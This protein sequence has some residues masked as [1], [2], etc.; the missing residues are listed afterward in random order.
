MRTAI[1]SLLSAILFLA[2]LVGCK[3]GNPPARTPPQTTQKMS[4]EEKVRTNLAKLSPEDQ[5]LA[6]EQKFCAVENKN[7]LGSMGVPV[8]VMIKD[9]PVFLCCSGCEEQA[10]AD[11]DATL[12]KVKELKEQNKPDGK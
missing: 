8:K 10:K 5:K 1:G 12:A 7:E 6:R 3:N 2:A 4:K 9:Q 11:P